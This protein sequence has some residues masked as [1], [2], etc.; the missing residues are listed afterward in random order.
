VGNWSIAKARETYNIEHWSAGYFDINEQ[1]QVIAF[2]DGNRKEPGINLAELVPAIIERGLSLP[3]LVRF[4]DILKQRVKALNTAFAAAISQYD[5]QNTYTAVYPIKVNQQR[6]VV[7]KIHHKDQF[8]TGLEAGSKPELMAV[9]ALAN[10]PG[11]IIV[12]NGYKDREYIRMALIGR[13]LGHHV[14]IIIEKMSELPLILAEAKKLNVTPKLGIRIRTAS[15]GAGKWQ[16]TG[17]EKA[18]FGLSAAQVLHIIEQLQQAEQLACLELLHCHIGSQIANIRDIQRGMH[19]CARYY[20][21]L[22]QLGANIRY[23]DVGGG[24]GVDY[25]GTTS[26]SFCSMNY[27]LQEYANNVIAALTEICQTHQLPHP[28]VFTECGRAMTAHH[29]VLIT[30]ITEIEQPSAPANIEPAQ[31]DEPPVIKDLWNS[32]SKLSARTALEVYHD[33]CYWLSEAHSMYIHGLL[34][35]QERARAEELYTAA[36]LTIKD[37]LQPNKRVHQEILDEINEKLAAKFFCNFS[38]FQSLP[39]VWAIKQIFP[40]IPLSQL[41]KNPTI[42]GKLQDLTCDS[43][44]C[45]SNYIDGQSLEKTLPLPPFDAKNPYLLGIFLVGAYQEILGDMHNLFGD[46]DSV[47]VEL[48]QNGN[49]QLVEPVKGETVGN[50]LG[51]VHFN[52]DR[53][54]D[55]YR[56]QLQQA[57]LTPMQLEQYF[58]E[59]AA[60]LSGYTYLED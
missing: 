54:L 12:C 21:E 5:Y 59:L 27:T 28:G 51:S 22:H 34:N 20:A 19:E 43:D 57:K 32:F 3:V 41:D 11:T 31:D 40:I 25:E 46:T 30:N 2:P 44:G 23:V 58:S 16:N 37:L 48:T 36:C 60:G 52:M 15:I 35:L 49:Y 13:Q 53:L 26:R 45:I 6:R 1:G 50:V 56:S 38:V 29:A 9:L 14:Y 47:H 42:R 39:D 18:K 10:K 24:L 8:V 33:I 4:T 7:E 17:G 55:A